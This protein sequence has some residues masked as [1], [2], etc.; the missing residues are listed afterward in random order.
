MSKAA[1]DS[2]PHFASE[3]V[4]IA[5]GNLIQSRPMPVM[6]EGDANCT[7]PFRVCRDNV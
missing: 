2:V 1:T 5:S 6:A 7:D 3:T 4:A